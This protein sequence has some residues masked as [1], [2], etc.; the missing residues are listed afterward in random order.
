M[1]CKFCIN[2][3]EADSK[4]SCRIFS[5][6]DSP[7]GKCIKFSADGALLDR[8]RARVAALARKEPFIFIEFVKDIIFSHKFKNKHNLYKIKEL[9]VGY[10]SLI[11]YLMLSPVVGMGALVW[12]YLTMDLFLKKM[13]ATLMLPMFFLLFFHNLFLRKSDLNRRLVVQVDSNGISINGE[14]VEWSSF[15]G[16]YITTEDVGRNLTYYME[17]VALRE[18][19]DARVN[20]T[21]IEI[22][23]Y[24][25]RLLVDHFRISSKSKR[26][27]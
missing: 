10:F 22:S 8:E 24:Q 20:I 13:G 1:K 5:K 18:L 4:S 21:S 11:G 9:K 6:L 23:A 7:S 14:F 19:K 3:S 16:L 2:Y 12:G 25:L 26:G 27:H 15:V 17:F